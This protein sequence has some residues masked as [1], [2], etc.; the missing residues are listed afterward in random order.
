[1]A[2]HEPCGFAYLI[3][4]HDG[5][6]HKS[7][8]VYR[9]ENAV[10]VFLQKISE[11][12]SLLEEK[13]KKVVPMKISEKEKRAYEEAEDCYL[14][15]GALGEDRVRD[16][17]H[18]CGAYRGA[19]H[20]ICNLNHKL[21]KKIPVIF[22]NLRN[23]DGH[24]IIS[25]LGRFPEFTADVIPIN[26][27]KYIAF[28]LKKNNSPIQLVFLDSFQFLNKS[29]DELVRNLDVG[30][31]HLLKANFPPSAPLDLL[32][33]K[34]VYPYSYIT[35]WEVFNETVLP[36]PSAFYNDLTE[37]PVEE[38]DYRHAHAVWEAFGIRT[39]GHYHDLYVMTDVLLLADVFQNFRQL[40]AEF[41]NLDPC[42]VFT[43]AGLSWEACL[44][45][46]QVKLELL[47]DIDMLLFI[48]KGVRGGVSQISHRFAKA[49]NPLVPG[50]RDIGS[51]NHSYIVY[52]DANN[53]YGWSMNQF[54]PYGGFEWVSCAG[55]TE[56][57]ILSLKDTAREGFI[58]EVDLQYPEHLHDAHNDF[59][60]APEKLT[61][62]S[63]MLSPYALNLLHN[64]K[65]VGTPKLIPNLFAKKNYVIHYRTLKL[66]LRLGLQ[67]GTIHRVLKFKQS[68]WLRSYIDFNTEKRKEATNEFQRD[69]FKLMN[70]SVYG[71]TIESLRKRRR[72][73][74]C[75]T[76]VRGEKLAA[77]PTFKSFT[78][79]DENLVAVE[80]IKPN[81][82]MNRPIYVGFVIL[83][84]SK[85]L[86]YQFHY[87]HIR[88]IYGDRA[89]LLFTDTDS[90]TYHIKTPDLY[91]DL[92]LHADL[93]DFSDY[94]ESHPLHSN[95]N[96][97]VLG[98]FKDE[99]KGEVGLEFVGLKAKMYSLQNTGK[100]KK[101][102]KGVSHY[103]VRNKI[104]HEDYVKCLHDQQTYVH[105]MNKINQEHHRLSTVRLKKKTL[106][107]FDDKRYLLE[108]G[109]SS[110]AYGHWKIKE[111]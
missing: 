13:L 70:N 58:F 15:D 60:L 40:C 92:R 51:N 37:K 68:P 38:K 16:H 22:H 82:L 23:Y 43:A 34:G 4:D 109:E 83:E 9:G 52:L 61:L 67:L 75:R 85:Y 27:E 103:V 44:K 30:E 77:D 29:L 64:S 10:E 5:K 76:E 66:Y 49:Y 96:K 69:F 93:F 25:K 50:Y 3:V 98:K 62:T 26:M 14:C 95:M 111:N 42:H 102:A 105:I 53:L 20:N 88:G 72:V 74:L 35:N 47:T 21:T 31:F 54:L 45:K 24:L 46:T 65:Y 57:W 2:A 11:E 89:R 106:S 28:I 18:L 6:T 91:A 84:L 94:P 19:L 39:L 32:R 104:E 107:P 99:L 36:P 33:R 12:T 79:F 78:V 41:Y 80:R 81:I 59:P 7:I 56:E 55:I 17:C 90:L 8:E 1:M 63:D 108:D 48:E 110:Y 101:R 86:M 100:L 73:E 87:D 71:K 97:K